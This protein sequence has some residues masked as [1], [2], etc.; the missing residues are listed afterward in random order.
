MV[1]RLPE[2]TAETHS[3]GG[4]NKFILLVLVGTAGKMV[5]VGTAG[6]PLLPT[7]VIT[8]SHLGTLEGAGGGQ[9]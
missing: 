6:K 7:C 1:Q 5:L 4:E 2:V 9:V 3:S 8:K